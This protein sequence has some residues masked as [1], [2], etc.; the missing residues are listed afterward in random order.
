MMTAMKPPTNGVPPSAV[1]P[2]AKLSDLTT[3]HMQSRSPLA[4][5]TA[6]LNI[7][8]LNTKLGSA[9]GNGSASAF[10]IPKLSAVVVA[11]QPAVQ[12]TPHAMSMRKIMDLQNIHLSVDGGPLEAARD[13]DKCA[14]S[15]VLVNLTA[16]AA[17]GVQPRRPSTATVVD[18]DADMPSVPIC[19]PCD[20]P[21]A[22]D[23]DGLAIVSDP[24]RALRE[25]LTV[26]CVVDL[27]SLAAR[28]LPHKTGARSR[29]GRILC[30]RYANGAA[31]QSARAT[32]RHGFAAG[33]HAVRAYRFDRPS[34]DDVIQRQLAKWKKPTT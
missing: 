23:A 21:P 15:V 34:P 7:P 19:H 2:F 8:K 11:V 4:N 25:N 9:T 29:I 6:K 17:H 33:R 26:E 1:S 27:S 12:L 5:G 14:A 22:T 28:K 3:F 18:A 24:L 16:A 10:V 31:L 20:A 13:A 32:V 30:S